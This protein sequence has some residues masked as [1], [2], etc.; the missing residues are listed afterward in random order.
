MEKDWESFS[1]QYLSSNFLVKKL[2]QRFLSSLRAV[3]SG[4]EVERI[5]EVGSGS[6][7]STQGLKKF[8][9]VKH[10]EASELRKDLVES[11]KERNPE[12]E[13][14]QE[15][16]YRLQREDNSFDLVIA[17]E[18]LEHLEYPEKALREIHRV[19]AKYCLIS[20]PREPLW[21][22]MNICRF[23]YWKDSGNTPGH[24][25]HWS[26]KQLI[27]FIS[28]YFKIEKIKTP[29]LWVVILGRKI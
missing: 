29:L 7:L 17:L 11:A 10:F 9:K 22:I 18:V 21:R 13:I 2:V 26:K 15:D 19:A 28:P 27:E 23:K 16:I 5:L 12:L 8:F 3:I 1:D 25:Q 4:I 24:L 6:G 14:R 20:V